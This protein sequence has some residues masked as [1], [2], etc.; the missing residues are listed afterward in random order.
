MPFSTKAFL[1]FCKKSEFLGKNS[2]F[3]Q[4]N[5]PSAMIEIF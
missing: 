3:T 5:S 2:T 4:S 1:I